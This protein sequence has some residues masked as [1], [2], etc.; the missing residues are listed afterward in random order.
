MDLKTGAVY[1]LGTG[2][3]QAAKRDDQILCNHRY[4]QL[5]V[6]LPIK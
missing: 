6:M 4:F 1:S 2:E 5:Y 3:F